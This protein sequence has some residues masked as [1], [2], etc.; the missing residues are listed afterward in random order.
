MMAIHKYIINQSKSKFTPRPR[1]IK[2]LARFYKKYVAKQEYF[3]NT[4]FNAR[5]ECKTFVG[6]TFVG[7]TFVGKTLQPTRPNPEFQ[8]CLQDFCMQNFCRQDFCM[9]DF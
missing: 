6:T 8:A 5:L 2:I 3:A 1:D 4:A 9:Q 7:E